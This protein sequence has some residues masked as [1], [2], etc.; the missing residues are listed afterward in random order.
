M[1]AVKELSGGMSNRIYLIGNNVL[2]RVFGE[3]SDALID[4]K[5]EAYIM[6]ELGN[7]GIS[8]KILLEFKGGRLEEFIG[9]SRSL[10]VYDLSD[11]T[12]MANLIGKIKQLHQLSLDLDERPV[13]VENVR[14]WT[15][16][17][18]AVNPNFQ[19][20]YDL[21]SVILSL[22]TG[23]QT[24]IRLCHND[25]QKN[26]I[27]VNRD[28]KDVKL[29]DFEY[30]G[31]NFVEFEL[32]NF[33]FELTV[34]YTSDSFKIHDIELSKIHERVCQLYMPDRP[35]LANSLRVFTM[36]AHYLWATWAIIKSRSS[37]PFDYIGYAKARFNLLKSMLDK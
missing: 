34:N 5:T 31:Y 12:I 2:L 35:E 20:L 24:T 37:G 36:A 17:A 3:S 8:P 30:A 16:E 13:L 18:K 19:Q 6:R 27:L 28:T 33:L 29:I 22:I 14:R 1:D 10:T 7:L 11:D 15:A 21:E 4:L 32:A 23:V 9:N 25:L 26:N